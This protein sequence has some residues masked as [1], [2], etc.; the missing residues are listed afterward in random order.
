[1][2]LLDF[3]FGKSKSGGSP[4]KGLKKANVAKRFDLVGRTGQGSMSKVFRAYDRELG[5]TVCLKL[6]DKAKTK[7]FEERFI[8][9][10]K[11]HEGEICEALKHDNIVRTY[12][13]GVTTDGE[14]YLVME[15]VDGLGLNYLVETR[16]PQ[17]TGNRINFLSQLCN[18]LQYM[19][20]SKWLHRDLCTRNVMVDKEGVLKL[21]DFG[22]TVPYTP[23]FCVSGNRTGTPDIL[24][25]EIIK[26]K[27]TDHRVDLFALGVTA[28]EVFTGQLPWERSPS[29]E[30]TFRRRLNTAP[31]EAKD[32]N[33]QV[34]ERL[35]SIL[36]KSISREP[37]DRYPSANAFKDALARLEKQDY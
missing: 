9:L 7:K 16:A 31:R 21:I 18:A 28:Y 6:L 8:G 37:A 26:R 15:L 12:E 29:S 32:L 11:P 10:K 24:A 27:A 17:L 22:L 20:D 5:R 4:K 2:G 19:H 14:P 34:D 35:S 33:P 13:Q 30:E 23:A 36:L 25:P 3:L 1:M